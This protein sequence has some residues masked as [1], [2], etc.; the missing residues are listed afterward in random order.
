MIG[1]LLSSQLIMLCGIYLLLVVYNFV[2]IA[3]ELHW[4]LIKIDILKLSYVGKNNSWKME[5]L[6]IFCLQDQEIDSWFTNHEPLIPTMLGKY[7][8]VYSSIRPP[9]H[10]FCE[11]EKETI[12]TITIHTVIA[13]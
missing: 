10:S 6:Q 3:Q 5:V 4:K 12:N 9:L 8:L 2:M 7:S 11:K 1:S 13:R